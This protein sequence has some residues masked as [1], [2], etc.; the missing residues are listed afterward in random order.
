[1]RIIAPTPA[2]R[3][4]QTVAPEVTE[5][6]LSVDNAGGRF[7]DQGPSLLSGNGRAILLGI[8]LVAVI[9]STIGVIH[10]R[11]QAARRHQE[12]R[13]ELLTVATNTISMPSHPEITPAP[14]VVKISADVIHVTAI[15]LGHP[16][17][18]II[19]GQQVTEGD[20]ITV[21]TPA[22]SVAVTLRVLKIVDGRIDLSDGTQV[23]TARLDI[24]SAPH[25]KP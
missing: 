22:A 24:P 15:S 9:L 7:S 18:A 10:S 4:L 12:E 21:H 25:H 2:P 8:L 11:H 5:A 16:R 3:L 19:N 6:K 17:L 1:M 14:I 20:Q 23:M 13:R